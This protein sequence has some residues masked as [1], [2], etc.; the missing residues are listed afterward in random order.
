M[1]SQVS[2]AVYQ[3]FVERLRL[4]PV[5]ARRL[6]CVIA[7][8]AYHG[9]LRSKT[10][11]TATMPEVHEACGLD[12]DELYDV[13]HLLQQAEF[14]TV[15]DSYPFEEMKLTGESPVEAAV[16]QMV[17]NRCDAGKIPLE[18]ALVDLHLES[19]NRIPLE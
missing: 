18:S 6:F 15:L 9:T 10:P 3:R 19:L 5:Q 8:Q 11:G 1:G 2:A 16:L 12:V 13:L 7:R 4:L 14:V 17:L